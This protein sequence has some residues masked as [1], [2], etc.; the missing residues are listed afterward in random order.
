MLDKLLSPGEWFGDLGKLA[1]RVALGGSMLFAHGIPKIQGWA[2]KSS[3]F[4]DPFGIGNAPS[5]ALAISA[6][7]FAASLLILGALTRLSLLPL[8]VTMAVA[9]FVIHGADPYSQKELSFIYLAG[10][11]GLFFV[12]PG[13]ISLD[14]VLR[15]SSRKS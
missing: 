11:T 14:A 10:F 15:G 13:R 6:E 1:L 4:P 5:M 8:I 7:A 12:G 9:F 2:E 3:V